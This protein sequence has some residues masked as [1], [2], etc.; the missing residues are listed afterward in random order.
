VDQAGR[1]KL[2]SGV[3]VLEP[4]AA[5]EIAWLSERTPERSF[6]SGEMVYAEGD[7]SDVLF[8]SLAGRIR[9]YGI[10]AGQ[11]FT[12]EVIQA[13]TIFGES[14]LAGRAQP[15]HAQA[16][17]L[18][19]VGVLGLNTF[20]QLLRQNPEVNARVVKLLVTRS[21]MN[22]RRMKDLAV[23]EVLARLASLILDLLQ[24]EGVVTREGH[25][26]IAA[27]YTQEQLATM[28]GAKRVAVTR[29][30]GHLQNSGS[31]QLLRRQIY[32][33]DLAALAR[34]AVEA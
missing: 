24:R 13:G 29:A 20:W 18:A 34:L 32:V 25:Y 28:I 10:S 23:K 16:L 15:E 17:E 1:I 26:K 19:L 5:E 9:L 12:F 14:S 27:P 30:F 22:R 2:L 6:A 3:D 33:T 4:L 7:A 21:C 8:F 11:E 31:V